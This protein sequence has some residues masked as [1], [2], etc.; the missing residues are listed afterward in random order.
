MKTDAEVILLDI[1][2]TTTHINF[3]HATLFPF[4]RA[5]LAD[6]LSAN[7]D[8]DELELTLKALKAEFDKD[9]T[10]EAIEYTP[11]NYLNFLMDQDKK[12]PSLKTIQG[13]I[14]ESGYKS[15]DIKGDLFPD[16]PAALER[17]RSE[18]KKAYIY[19]SGSVLAQKLLFQFSVAGNLTCFLYGHFD[20]A[21]GAKVESSSY[22]TIAEKIYTD[23]SE[24]LF[25]SDAPKELIAARKAG[26]QVMFSNRP[27]NLYANDGEFDEVTSFESL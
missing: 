16:V 1:E 15:G 20:T 27:G 24:I 3:V 11:L 21:I 19:S 23:P 25:V 26:C 18:G 6:F 13:K 7:K 22:K 4:A 17:W 9:I 12:S 2:G 14:W 5:R 8:S 10:A